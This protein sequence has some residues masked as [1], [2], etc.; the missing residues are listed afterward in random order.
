VTEVADQDGDAVGEDDRIEGKVSRERSEGR[1]SKG[2]FLP[3]GYRERFAEG[4]EVARTRKGDSIEEGID[5][6]RPGERVCQE[7]RAP[8]D[9]PSQAPTMA[10]FVSLSPPPKAAAAR[11]RCSRQ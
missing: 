9:A 4:A 2:A 5:G 6:E 11:S 10:A 3:R 1:P 7:L 8:R